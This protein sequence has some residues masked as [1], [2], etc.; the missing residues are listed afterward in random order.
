MLAE[1]S[2]II[3]QACVPI[4]PCPPPCLPVLTCPPPPLPVPG[5]SPPVL[6]TVTVVKREEA[7]RTVTLEWKPATDDHAIVGY[8][9][10]RD[11]KLLSTAKGSQLTRVRFYVPCGRHAFKVE[12]VDSIGQRTSRLLRVRRRCV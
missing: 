4:L 12:A 11:G 3:M 7:S 10:Y 2:F 8:R 1:V 9:F 5:D 6:P